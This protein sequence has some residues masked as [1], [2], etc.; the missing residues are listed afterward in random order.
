MPIAGKNNSLKVIK[1]NGDILTFDAGK[2]GEIEVVNNDL[3]LKYT[4]G[5]FTDVFLLPDSDGTIKGFLGQAIVNAGEFAKLKVVANTK[6]GSFFDM[7]IEKDLFCPFAEQKTTLEIN[8]YYLVYVYIDEITN[9]LSASTRIDKFISDEKP[10]LT[11]QQSVNII[12]LNKSQLGYNAIVEN[13]YYGLLYDNEVF[14][15]LKPGQKHTAII[16]KIR[17]DNKIDL[18]LYKN[19]HNDISE[20]ET[21]ILNYLKAHEG[22]M[23]LNDES[24]P[25]DIYDVFGI[26]KKNFKKALGAL[27]RKGVID[28]KDKII[29]LLD[30]A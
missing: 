1:V 3:I 16:K 28:L 19:D 10:D 15:E 2:Y 25:Q 17:E 23:T 6:F 26:S 5:Q 29:K 9:R 8:S 24:D 30:N 21:M 18:R 12:I 11:E 7:G 27:Y 14:K 13:K 20:F 4:E 22:K